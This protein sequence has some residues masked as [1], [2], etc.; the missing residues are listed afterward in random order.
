MSVEYIK[1]GADEARRE[2]IVGDMKVN[3]NIYDLSTIAI[4]PDVDDDILWVIELVTSANPYIIPV[5]HK[6][7]G[8]GLYTLIKKDWDW[9]LEQE[10]GE[11]DPDDSD[12]QC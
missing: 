10:N 11:F 7:E 4:Y 3:F 1:Y 2:L 9:W 5:S 6:E 12:I 8:E